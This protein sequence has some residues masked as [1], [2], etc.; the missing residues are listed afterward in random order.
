[1]SNLQAP[2]YKQTRPG[3]IHAM[4]E[5]GKTRCGVVPQESWQ[6]TDAEPTCKM[7]TGKAG[8][9]RDMS[10]RRRFPKT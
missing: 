1:M 8:G 5:Y 9:W 2:T 4:G 7:C 6:P 3:H 10:V